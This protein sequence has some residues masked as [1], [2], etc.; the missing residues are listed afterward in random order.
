[1]KT[2]DFNYDLPE[3]LI[4]Q[5]PLENRTDSRLLVVNKDSGD[6]VHEQFK[7]LHRYLK[8]GDVMVLNDTAVIPA[9][10][11]GVKKD[12]GAVIEVL[13][14]HQKADDE[15]ECLVKKARKVRV[16]TTLSFG[17]GA[18]TME[19]TGVE[20]EGIRL[21]KMHYSGIFYELLERLGET[22]LPP[23]IHEKLDDP[24]RYQTVY[25]EKK[26]SAAAPTAG[27]HFT[28]PYLESLRAMG[29]GIVHL[30]LHV[31]LGTFRP[32][33]VEDVKNHVMHEEYYSVPEKTAD[34]INRAKRENRRI[35]AVGTTSLRTLET[36]VDDEGTVHAG[37]GWSRLFV[38]PPYTFKA[39]DALLTNFHLPESTLLMLVSAFASKAIIMDAYQ[40]AIRERYRFFSFGD[41]MFLTGDHE[42]D[43]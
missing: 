1:M 11:I 25:S 34:A 42:P 36:V 20:E 6:H 27:L 41:A 35:V 4:A 37:S 5:T 15:W 43:Q 2:S 21:F 22:P 10:L 18:L 31:G 26:G 39:V 16:G 40:A 38:Y 28:K 23:Y 17:D 3:S 7:N 13:L 19:C 14:L 33:S 29:I 32:V 24:D 12:T 30:T 8:E 9:R